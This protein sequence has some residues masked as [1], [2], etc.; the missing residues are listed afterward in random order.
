MR[1]KILQFNRATRTALFILLLNAVGLTKAYA[2]SDPWDFRAVCSSG[3]RLYYRIVDSENHYVNVRTPVTHWPSGVYDA[4]PTD[5]DHMSGVVVIPSAV[6]YEN[7]VYTVV[8]IESA[9]YSWGQDPI[10]ITGVVIPETV[11]TI[12]NLAFSGCPLLSGGLE[13]PSQLTSIGN[14]AFS[15]CSNL[16]GSLVIPNTVTTIGEQAFMNCSGFT[17][18]LVI[19]NAVTTI[20][21]DAFN[22][23]TGLNGTLT[24]G[25]SVYQV[26]G[27]AFSNTNFITVVY[28]AINANYFGGN[29][30]PSEE[31]NRA[32]GECSSLTT[33]IIGNQVENI[34]FHAFSY[35]GFEGNLS[36][37]NSTISIGHHAFYHC[38]NFDGI[39]TIGAS[40]ADIGA[41]TFSYTDFGQ[42]NFNATACDIGNTSVWEN[43]PQCPL[44]IGENVTHISRYSFYG[45]RFTG[46][47][48]IPNS[49]TSV[50]HDAF[51]NC[52]GITA[53]TI[54]EGVTSLGLLPQY[55]SVFNNCTSLA[56]V[57]F[58]A[59]NCADMT[60][61]NLFE[62]CPALTSLYIGNN[63]G[64]IPSKAFKN[65]SFS[66]TIIIPNSV[67]EIG[68][69]AFTNCSNITAVT[70][71]EGLTKTN[72]QIFSGC[73]G[74]A[75]VNYNAINCTNWNTYETW[76]DCTS[77]DTLFIGTNVE[78]IPNGIF[79]DCSFA[80]NLV[81]PNSLLT[82]GENAFQN[83]SGFT[84]DLIIPDNV[85]TIGANAFHGCSGFTGDLTIGNSVET[86]GETAFENCS[87][88]TGTLTIGESYSTGSG[89][90]GQQF[91][92]CSGLTTLNYNAINGPV[93]A[94]DRHCLEGCTSLT[95]LNIGPNVQVIPD[96]AFIN[97]NFSNDIVIPNSVTTIGYN[98]FYNCDQ[99][100]TITIGEGVTT[101]ASWAIDY[102]DGLTTIHYNAINCNVGNT[103]IGNSWLGNC[104]PQATTLTIGE[105][106][107]SIFKGAFSRRYGGVSFIGNLTLPNSL[108]TI[109]EEAFLDC[110]GLTG[111]LVI[112]N[113]VTSIG[114]KA[115]SGCTGF[116]GN[117]T[118]GNGLT[119]ID[120]RT[121]HGCNGFIGTL[122]IGSSVE[123]I[124]YEAFR[125]CSGFTGDLTIPNSVIT[126][127]RYCFYDCSGFDGTLTVGEGVVN[128][129]EYAPF[130]NCSSLTAIN[131]NAINATKPESGNWLWNCNALTTLTIGPNVESIFE[132]AFDGK[133][134]LTGNLVI[135]NSVTTIEKNAFKGCSGFNGTLTLSNN[136]TSIGEAAFKDCTGFTGTLTIPSSLTAIDKE[137][138]RNCHSITGNLVIPT[139]ILTIDNDA[140][141]DCYGLNGSLT[142]ASSVAS[143]GTYSIANTRFTTIYYN[144]INA[145]LADG[146]WLNDCNTPTTLAIGSQ[147]Q[148]IP[149]NAFK[150]KRFEG[151]LVIPN[152][153]TS[154]GAGAFYNNDF[155]TG[156]LVIPN[157]VAIIGNSA[158]QDCGG[159]NGTLTLPATMTSIGEAAFK[160]CR[161]I[162]GTLT[163]P[164]GLVTIEKEA[165]R[166]MSSLTGN[167]VIP[168][169]VQEIKQQAFI[170]CRSL[171]GT[172]TLSS[173][174]ESIGQ[175][176][177]QDCNSL[178]G[179]LTLPGT[180]TT[181][182]I[183]A[184]KN[185]RGFTGDLVIP[186]TVTSLPNGVFYDC[187]GLNG[188]LIIGES[189][190]SLDDEC[191]YKASNFQSMT[192][193]ANNPPVAT[194]NNVFGYW[195]KT[196]PVY[197]PCGA[198][199]AYQA[200]D[201]WSE[202]S[203]YIES[204]MID[205]QVSSAD[206]SMGTASITQQATCSNSQATVTAVANSGYMFSYWTE[207]EEIVSTSN[208][209]SFNLTATRNLVAHFEGVTY[210]INASANPS[211]GGTITGFGGFGE[212]ATATLTATANTG[213]T[214]IN[215]TEG[216]EVVSTN[217]TYTFTVTGDR[218]LVA[219]FS[220][221]SYNITAM[222]NPSAGGSVTGA[223]T[224]NYGATAT[225]TATANTGYTFVN[226][227]QGG[228]EVST[229]VTYSF[230][231]TEA[232]DFVANF[233]LN[234][235]QIMATAN[236]SAQGAVTG[237]GTYDHGTT[238]TLTATPNQGYYFVNWTENDVEV[239]TNST[240]TFTVTEARTLV[241]NFEEITLHWTV[242]QGG[243]EDYMALTSV[244]QI[245]GVEQT[246]N[247]LEVGA[248]CDNQ[249]RG[250][251][252]AVYWEIPQLN[253]YVVYLQ[254]YGQ[255]GD[256][257]NFKLFDHSSNQ[258]LNLTSPTPLTWT[259][260]TTMY[261]EINPYVL[262]FTSQVDITASVDPEDAGTV[263]G[264][265]Q[266]ALG[267]TCTLSATANTGFQ[268]KNWTL[269]STVVSTDATYS[270]TVS[271]GASYT[272]HFDC[273]HSQ[274]L[275]NGWNWWSTYVQLGSNGL[276]MLENGLG[277]NADQIK[278]WT[279][280]YVN[281]MEYLG[282]VFW[283]GSLNAIHNDQ[284]YMINTN[285][286][287]VLEM[288]GEA[289]SVGN[290]PITLNPG[291]NWIGF[292]SSQ[293]IGISTALSQF[294]PQPNDMIKGRNGYASYVTYGTYGF[295]SGS[296]N[297]LV[298]GQ[299]YKYFSTSDSPK[300]VTYGS[301]K[302]DAS[303][304]MQ[305]PEV[306]SLTPVSEK[307][308]H[309]MTLTA[310]V[311]LAGDELRSKDYELA[312]F[313]GNE[314]RGSVKL[315]YVEPLDRFLAFLL[316]FGE[317]NESLRF[318][319]TDGRGL[320][321]SVD[322][323]V[324]SVD[325]IVGSPTEPVVLHFGPLG[326]NEGVQKA[327]VVYP[328]P[329]KDVFNIMGKGIRKIEVVNAFGQI[330]QSKEVSNDFITID[331][332]SKAC[333]AYLLRVITNDGVMT[334][335]LI[336]NNN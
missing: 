251:N 11:T 300:T 178:T 53:V 91:G 275:S 71:G 223:D 19:P 235:Y 87:G 148:V 70:I 187:S 259:Q 207:G 243:F 167:L 201:Y 112:P 102:C 171:N 30:N 310:V 211:A 319:L 185:C 138:F 309:N 292:P 151:Q 334:T 88:F 15:G 225:L 197:I 333:G 240:Y 252:M 176:A 160:D 245:D 106:V 79:K 241:A 274:S 46:S 80:C 156:D 146:T 218:T 217:A 56:T 332:G 294:A 239:S 158:F 196:K 108:Q 214:F 170:N 74:L 40:V 262:N 305:D 173:S 25:E 260:N 107:Q 168:N 8:G 250:A 31:K 322:R 130:G 22:G 10:P 58:N 41:N 13:L 191:F 286:S 162:T 194:N 200:A 265:G 34:P 110:T 111:S 153:V 257:I 271:E 38:D 244:I 24:I 237:A 228:V 20:G 124:G 51:T 54:G 202:F 6:T 304:V 129:N 307:Y 72:G 189:M 100:T 198:S 143:V 253:R 206:P 115:F 44:S 308:A 132:S 234:S 104:C 315:M 268:F 125:G 183:R 306:C 28:N 290:T 276:A 63:V 313:V 182:G 208:P 117:L 192:V 179:D 133:S 137:A 227:T 174:L 81:L 89:I 5:P 230:T 270:F 164:A 175:E 177:F 23:C 118:I 69:E 321:W 116:T 221:N 287:C 29:S 280:G 236:S 266:Y 14:W 285:Q 17:G 62:N 82:I 299:G 126:L 57:F 67:T 140:F 50:G 141:R 152:S 45:G 283:S 186:N 157:S 86:I 264:E 127:G 161:N 163:L 12:G 255:D 134:S 205:L 36:I 135:P 209:Y 263:T 336:K 320:N 226:W 181:I 248:F 27:G 159:F 92:Y 52:T 109:G 60:Y 231:V 73:T 220:L 16:T 90:W 136:L 37:P 149:D 190:A 96:R 269:G 199:T 4:D 295:W 335:K 142:I 166:E 210:T 297:T 213:Y 144:A 65:C 328:N 172:L 78:S 145:D 9:F 155:F 312:A 39:L 273:V 59:V 1:I 291:W 184:F 249:C 324:Y 331:L 281:R 323:M 55:G 232:A 119:V 180:L 99:I 95:T 302:A 18:N 154:I 298:S 83:C 258:E 246:S 256:V 114:K 103:T 66:G 75:T 35:C 21:G 165:F 242:E 68:G 222:A 284:M 47:V 216:N 212:G 238:C 76:K 98:A 97:L 3:Q 204:P 85:T 289:V 33:L 288:T 261:N 327:V 123:T 314:C 326:V 317:E 303:V 131:Y 139:G 169:S 64:R 279:D 42:V 195:D 147:V 121:F 318:A 215:W 48:V 330:I 219:N 7:E 105:H 49:V 267:S 296:L 128:I 101:M 122:T 254:V 2:W 43:G 301:S 203:N 188:E 247:Q 113:S 26:D 311:E 325:G 77:L 61:S 277:N 84:G 282:Y 278:S 316:V 233:S 94:T 293:N 229:N 32:F 120:E 193:R 224:Y 93:G 272:A 150:N 329:S